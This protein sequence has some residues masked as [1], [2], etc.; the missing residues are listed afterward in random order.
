MHFKFC[1]ASILQRSSCENSCFHRTRELSKLTFLSFIMLWSYN[2]CN[3]ETVLI[4]ETLWE[5]TTHLSLLSSVHVRFVWWKNVWHGVFSHREVPI[6]THLRE[7]ARSGAVLIWRTHTHTHTSINT[8]VQWQN[9]VPQRFLLP[10]FSFYQA[11]WISLCMELLWLL[12][13]SSW[14]QRQRRSPKC[15]CEH[16]RSMKY[17]TTDCFIRMPTR[18]FIN[19]QFDSNVPAASRTS[20]MSHTFPLKLL[21]A[22]FGL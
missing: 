18:V 15:V 14:S 6:T 19:F 10:H 4:F 12:V 5:M 2:M 22:W 9:C 3:V 16:A 11:V 8:Q 17:L 21:S 7:R 20:I 1:A 13:R